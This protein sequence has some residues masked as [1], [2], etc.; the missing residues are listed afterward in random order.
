VSARNSSFTYKGR[1][2]DV[3][4]VGWELGVRYVIEGSVRIAANRVRITCQLIDASNGMHIWADR[5]DC[6]LE[7]IFD[8]QDRLTANLVSAIARQLQRAV[9]ERARSKPLENLTSRDYFLRGMTSLYRLNADA[10]NDTLDHF[11]KAIALDPEFSTAYGMAVWCYTWRFTYGWMIDPAQEHADALGLARC[12]IELGANDAVA[13]GCGGWALGFLGGGLESGAELMDRARA[14]N[15]HF[16]PNWY[17]SGWLRVFLGDLEA[18]TSHLAQVL[19]LSPSDPL[20]VHTKNATAWTHFLAGR[21]DEAFSW[22]EGALQE[23]PRHKPA[24]RVSAA[25]KARLGMKD[26]ARTTVARMGQIDP[27]FRISDVSKSPHFEGR[28]TSKSSKTTSAR[29]ASGKN[30]NNLVCCW[31]SRSAEWAASAPHVSW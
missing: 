8:L 24:L 29:L 5:Y 6:L 10:S 1:A 12:A 14:L 2:V 30:R 23:N 4:Q 7:D 26:E 19:R 27:S 20:L 13:L 16:A 18:A 15:P 25:I 28:R 9:I 22:V 31:L 11:K 21:H 17:F 3:R